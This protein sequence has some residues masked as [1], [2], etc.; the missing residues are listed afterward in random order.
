[1]KNIGESF[2]LQPNALPYVNHM[3][4][5]QCQIVILH[6]VVISLQIPGVECYEKEVQHYLKMDNKPII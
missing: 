2:F 5:L 3:R 6:L 4:G 1:M